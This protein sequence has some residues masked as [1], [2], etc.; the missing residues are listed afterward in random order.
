LLIESLAFTMTTPQAIRCAP[1]LALWL[2]L[3]VLHLFVSIHAFQ[4]SSNFPSLLSTITQQQSSEGSITTTN[5]IIRTNFNGAESSQWSLQSSKSKH[6][7]TPELERVW[8]FVKKPLLRIGAKGATAS[9]GNSLRQLLDDHTAVKVK[10]NTAPYN[11]DLETAFESLKQLAVTSGASSDLELLQCRAR[12]QIILVSLP[13]TRKM[14]EAGDYP[15]PPPLEEE[16][17][18]DSSDSWNGWWWITAT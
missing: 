16:Q 7:D 3:G 1:A 5:S 15:P 17:D 13:G 11:G 14:I 8:R 9:H 4:P 6:N 2:L 10:I 18:I 12:E